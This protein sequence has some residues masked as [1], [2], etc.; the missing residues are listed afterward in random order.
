M[1]W[2]QRRRKEENLKARPKNQVEIKTLEEN[3]TPGENTD[4][5]KN[6]GGD[7]N[8]GEKQTRQKPGG[9]TWWKKTPEGNKTPEENKTPERKQNTWGK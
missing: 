2:N 3:K 7:K 9:E 1:W 6:P 5:G 8:P 4:Q